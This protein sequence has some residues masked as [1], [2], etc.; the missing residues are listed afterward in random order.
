[1]RVKQLDAAGKPEPL[2][3]THNGHATPWA[4]GLGLLAQRGAKVPAIF[5]WDRA[6][7][8]E[9]GDAEHV[10]P[11]ALRQMMQ[12]S[13]RTRAGVPAGAH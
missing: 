5:E 13:V 7:M 12:A 8:R 1:V 10:V 3:L 6:W 2:A 4:A 9:L 11:E